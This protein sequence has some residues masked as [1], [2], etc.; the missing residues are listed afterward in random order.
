MPAAG[1]TVLAAG[2]VSS[3]NYLSGYVTDSPVRAVDWCDRQPMEAIHRAQLTSVMP[4]ATAA[5]DRPRDPEAA[6]A[7]AMATRGR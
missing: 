2:S 7:P 4:L 6:Q 3:H 1:D 5:E